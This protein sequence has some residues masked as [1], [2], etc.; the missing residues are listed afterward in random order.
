[1]LLLGLLVHNSLIL[2]M[3][4]LFLLLNLNSL[5]SFFFNL[6]LT[7]SLSHSSIN[8]LFILVLY[9]CLSWISRIHSDSLKHFNGKIIELLSR[10]VPTLS[11]LVIPGIPLIPVY[12]LPDTWSCSVDIPKLSLLGQPVDSQ[13][14]ILIRQIWHIELLNWGA[15]FEEF[16]KSNELL[17]NGFTHVRDASRSIYIDQ[18]LSV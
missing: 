9:F 15:S 3:L 1:M 7:L 4:L 2:N 12:K 14:C 8:T 17:S 16:C 6:F 10:L 18:G 13:S 5:F 11:L